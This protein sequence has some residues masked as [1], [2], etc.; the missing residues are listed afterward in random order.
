MCLAIPT[1]VISINQERQT[2]LVNLDGVRKEISTALLDEVSPGDYVLI[3]VGY[4]LNK[5][6]PE[7]AQQTLELMG[8]GDCPNGSAE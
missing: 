3:H 7:Q 5:I 4:A 8:L 2:A 1:Q 6:D